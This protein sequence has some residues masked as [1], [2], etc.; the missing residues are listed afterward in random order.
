[1]VLYAVGALAGLSVAGY[2]LLSARGT[3]T[4][5]VPAENVA[6]VNDQP[7][8]RSDFITQVEMETGQPFEKTTRQD[9]LRVFDEMV[10]EE[11]KVQ[12]GLELN[13]AETDQDTRNALSAV[14]DQQM[15]AALATT[16][17]TDAELK[18]YY[19]RNES[20]YQSPGAMT[21]CDLVLSGAG[22]DADGRLVQARA[23][24]AD[25][26]NGAAL[27]KVMQ[28]YHLTNSNNCEN[29]YYFAARIH[30][31]S[32]LFEVARTLATGTVSEP[33]Q[34]SDG[35]HLLLMLSNTAPVGESF[36][37]ARAQVI[38][39]YKNARESKIRAGTMSFLRHRARILIASDYSDYHAQDH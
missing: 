10:N 20:S 34:G 6:L 35:L 18:T 31:G 8:L 37:D 24:E 9:K 4:R 1:M 7:I 23:A 27:P 26:R 36:A 39:D 38:T 22:L 14:V 11:L 21:V 25:L 16:Q 17:P 15:I 32:G 29:N 33:L 30:L 28:R 19:D 5:Q 13:F 12:R 2:V 3:V